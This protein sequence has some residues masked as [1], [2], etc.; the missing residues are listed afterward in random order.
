MLRNVVRD[1][2]KVYAYSLRILNVLSPSEP[3]GRPGLCLCLVPGPGRLISAVF[4]FLLA[5]ASR[6]ERVVASHE[7]LFLSLPCVISRA[8]SLAMSLDKQ[9]IP[10]RM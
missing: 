3:V 9:N 1:V 6:L 5:S 4:L 10:F 8:F 2:P 7:S